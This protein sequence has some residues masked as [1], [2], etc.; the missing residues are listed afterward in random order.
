[1]KKISYILAL[2]CFFL[3]SGCEGILDEEVYTFQAPKDYFSN[4][5]EVI[6][7][8]N[9]IYDALMTWELW[10]QPAWVSMALENDDMFAL[11]WVAGGYE[12]VQNGSWYIERPWNGFY[13]VINRANVVLQQVEPLEFLEADVKNAVL[14][15][16]YFMRG[17]S[18][19]EIARRFGD[20]PLRVKA[21]DPSTDSQD[22]GRSPVKEVYLQAATDLETAAG[23]LP[24][25]FARGVFNDGDRGRPTAPAA[26]GLLA[27]VY[28]HMAGAEVGETAYYQQAADAAAK[29]IEMSGSNG[30][31]LLEMDYMRN[32]EQGSQDNSNEILFSIQATQQPNEGPELPRYYTPGNTAYSGGGG[33]GAVMM[34]EDFYATFETGD[35]R[36]EF[37]TAIFDAWTD[38]NGEEFY[39]FRR[40]PSN[41]V[42]VISEGVTDNGFGRY[43]NNLYQT[44]EGGEVKGTP[45]LFIKKYIDESSQVK[46]ENGSNP[47]F[48]RYADVLLLYAEALNEV[49]GP[50][51]EAYI[52]LN[53]VRVRA[54]LSELDPG[55]DQTAFRTA[56]H[57][58]R[59]HELY[60]EF[61][62]RWD[63]IRWGTW[64]ETMNAANRP[65]L[66]Y[67]RLFPISSAEI[68]AN[69]MINANNPGW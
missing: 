5:A 41:V 13:Q 60:G 3:G 21:F 16:A 30:F 50:G 23:L 52:A 38:L 10:V 17:Y 19:Y 34:R 64:V 67:Q 4:E 28:M 32:F 15:Q 63:L 35:K 31:P 56:V 8:G 65:R 37:G 54:G 53:Q 1:M 58:E 45:S 12:G 61:Q 42:G 46:D 33:I 43:G 49:A 27:K 66:D 25:D 44:M 69:A 40:L 20:A 48:L 2:G 59:R 11:D 22:I 24:V 47:I 26:W 55:L 7:A 18:Y 36:V 6:A 62:R 29:V 14:G 57:L 68:A 9:G 51:N 39:H